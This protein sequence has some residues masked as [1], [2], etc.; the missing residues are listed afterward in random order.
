MGL[1]GLAYTKLTLERVLVSMINGMRQ[2]CRLA[3]EDHQYQDKTAITYT[4]IQGL[5][6]VRNNQR[7]IVFILPEKRYLRGKFLS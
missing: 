3:D 4:G 6:K 2:Q 5:D 1:L 7:S